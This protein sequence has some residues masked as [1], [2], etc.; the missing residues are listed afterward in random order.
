ML[1]RIEAVTVRQDLDS[2][3]EAEVE[4]PICASSDGKW[5]DAD[6]KFMK[7]FKRL[8]IEVKVGAGKFVPLFEGPLV[9]YD[10]RQ[11]S[12]PSQSVIHLRALDDSI[13]L[14]RK[15]SDSK[16]WQGKKVSEVVKQIYG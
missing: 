5:A 11:S 4:I 2:I 9:G 10:G 8:R 7:A 15:R 1:N 3:W 12:Q 13:L 6:E 14:T 16:N